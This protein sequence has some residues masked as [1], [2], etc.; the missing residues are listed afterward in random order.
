MYIAAHEICLRLEEM[1]R[2]RCLLALDH[3]TL[4][5]ARDFIKH[6][7]ERIEELENHIGPLGDNDSEDL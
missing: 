1:I 6:L 3:Q 4:E 7:V 5:D 2:N